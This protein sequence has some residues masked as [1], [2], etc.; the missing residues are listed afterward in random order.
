MLR[1]GYAGYWPSALAAWLSAAPAWRS[2][3][4]AFLRMWGARWLPYLARE[5]RWWLW[6]T[7]GAL[8]GAGCRMS[9]LRSGL[10]PHPN[11][12]SAVRLA[13]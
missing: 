10:H 13:L 12:S 4:G 7:P 11:L 9:G 5:R 1:A 2:F 3:D 6:V 8:L